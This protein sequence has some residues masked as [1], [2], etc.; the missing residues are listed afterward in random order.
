MTA[1]EGPTAADMRPTSVA[2]GLQKS[3]EKISNVCP[4]GRSTQRWDWEAANPLREA[5]SL[6]GGRREGRSVCGARASLP[7][8]GAV[9]RRSSRRAAW[10][11]SSR[12]GDGNRD[13]RRRPHIPTPFP[14]VF[15]CMLSLSRSPLERCFTP[16]C[17][18]IR[19]ETV[20]FPEPGGPMMT[21]RSSGGTT[22]VLPLLL[23]LPLL[24]PRAGRGAGGAPPS[25]GAPPRTGGEPRPVLRG[26]GS[27][28]FSG[29]QSGAGRKDP[30]RKCTRG[31]RDK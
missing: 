21:A 15:F 2:S 22:M 4:G 18:I 19:A 23:R 10:G 1:C 12:G 13:R 3:S 29:C 6:L 30:L 14:P 31:G 11:P 16:K 27:G 7:W 25:R 17:L 28:S 8:S 9:S 24:P 5:P 26:K 20:P